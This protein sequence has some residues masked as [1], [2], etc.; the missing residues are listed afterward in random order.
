MRVDEL[1]DEL[2]DLLVVREPLDSDALHKVRR[3]ARRARRQRQWRLGLL[4][5]AG[6]VVGVATID[7]TEQSVDVVSDDG[8]TST[9]STTGPT[10]SARLLYLAPATPPG[11]MTA[12][13]VQSTD[14]CEESAGAEEWERVERW[15]RLDAQGRR[16][17]ASFDVQWGPGPPRSPDDPFASFGAGEA[18]TVLGEEAFFHDSGSMRAV[19]WEKP[20]GRLNVVSSSTLPRDE[21]VAIVASL[22]ATADGALEVSH[23]PVGFELVAAWPGVASF[24]HDTRSI[25]FGDGARGFLL[26]LADESDYE[27]GMRL[28]FDD[29]EVVDVRGHRAVLAGGSFAVPG[30]TFGVEARFLSEPDHVLQWEAGSTLVTLAGRGLTHDEIV[31]TANSLVPVDA[32]AWEA[33]RP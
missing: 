24:G 21:L 29:S 13:H 11:A 15:V 23:P 31:E 26:T 9:P 22:G 28:S 30:V 14:C 12:L 8:E 10:A 33:L 7:R 3:R 2:E 20:A 6:L 25:A 5:A 16:P 19:V 4:V 18:M 32:A 17:D 1:R 27:P